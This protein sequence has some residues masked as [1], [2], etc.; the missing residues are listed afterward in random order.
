MIL[1]QFLPPLDVGTLSLQEKKTLWV[2]SASK[3][4]RPIERLLRVGEVVPTFADRGCCMVSA[5]DPPGRR[6]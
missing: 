3:P 6:S 5:M 4:C 2:W 1:S